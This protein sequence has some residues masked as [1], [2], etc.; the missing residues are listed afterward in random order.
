MKISFLDWMRSRVRF[1][2]GPFSRHNF[3]R[4]EYLAKGVK[5]TKRKVVREKNAYCPF[6]NVVPV[7]MFFHVP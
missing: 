2:Q 7:V 5:N 6:G 3:S 4:M 1:S